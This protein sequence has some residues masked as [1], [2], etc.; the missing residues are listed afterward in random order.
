MVLDLVVIG[1]LLIS[2]V[3]AFLR[4]FVREVLTIASLAGAGIVTIMF[5][6]NLKPMVAGWI[7]DPTATEKQTLFGVIPYEMLVPVIA[8]AIVFAL[9]L[10][11]FNIA[12]HLISRTVHS[13]GLGPVDRTMGVVFG[14][15]RGVIIIGLTGLVLNFVLSDEQRDLYFKDSKTYP[16]VTYTADLMQALMPSREVL[17]SKAKKKTQELL[18]ATGKGPLE[19]GQANQA[20]KPVKDDGG[21]TTLQRKAV[22]ALIPKNQ[23]PAEA[24]KYNE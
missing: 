9:A 16:A 12:T 5:G 7:I 6:P 1:I 4:G 13:V 24:K 19:P 18:A 2:A 3:V 21:Y 20:N 23:P 10:V 8:F 22:E 14:L 17:E 11:L 15:L